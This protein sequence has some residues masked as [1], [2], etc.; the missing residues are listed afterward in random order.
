M[1]NIIIVNKEDLEAK[2]RNF[3][4]DG[5]NKLHVISDFDKTLTTLFLPNGQKVN[6]LISIIRNGP[7]LGADYSKKSQCSI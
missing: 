5:P 7:Y 6:S 1:K 2:K 3:I 4:K